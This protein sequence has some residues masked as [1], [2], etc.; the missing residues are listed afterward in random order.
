MR[1][2]FSQRKDLGSTGDAALNGGL[3]Q[4]VKPACVAA[5]AARAARH[6]G[7]P[8]TLTLPKVP[9]YHIN[10]GVDLNN[11]FDYRCPTLS[12]RSDVCEVVG[13]AQVVTC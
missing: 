13:S 1:C 9:H 7:A 6:A 5:H 12:L 11:N 3:Q 8:V 10:P 2:R 4:A